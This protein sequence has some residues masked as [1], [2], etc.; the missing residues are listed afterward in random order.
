MKLEFEYQC[1]IP[2]EEMKGGD[3]RRFCENCNKHVHHIS[4]MT[5]EEALKF[6][7]K[8]NWEVCVDFHCDSNGEVVFKERE[9]RA[10]LQAEGLKQLLASAVAVVPLALAAAFIDTDGMEQAQVV[11]VQQVPAPIDLGG[12]A[13]VIQP[14]VPDFTSTH[15]PVVPVE[16]PP[17]PF[18]APFVAPEPVEEPVVESV[19]A[20][21]IKPR[22]RGRVRP[23]HMR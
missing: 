4:S 18:D 7:D 23:S 6:L 15:N 11:E 17:E 21:I 8:H 22:L 1:D 16:E 9:R 2:W 20:P 14:S 10:F 13:P 5:K 3:R 19:D 12:P